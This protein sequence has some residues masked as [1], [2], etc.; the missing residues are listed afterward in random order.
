M[1]EI[2]S[3][4]VTTKIAVKNIRKASERLA[5]FDELSRS[6]LSEGREPVP[7]IIIENESRLVRE[8]EEE[9]SKGLE[10]RDWV[11]KRYNENWR[12]RHSFFGASPVTR[13]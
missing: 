1:F 2:T 9:Y 6:A 8:A 10:F 5:R 12:N 3:F 4:N 13:Q 7:E 11:M